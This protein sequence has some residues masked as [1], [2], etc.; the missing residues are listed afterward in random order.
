MNEDFLP[1]MDAIHTFVDPKRQF[2]SGNWQLIHLYIFL[3]LRVIIDV[4]ES[5]NEYYLR[6]EW[7][8]LF[9]V[10]FT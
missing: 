1:D 8:T 5:V 7:K 6:F 4:I 9:V 2:N 3:H 10:Y